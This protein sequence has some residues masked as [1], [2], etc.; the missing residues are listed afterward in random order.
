MSEMNPVYLLD[1]DTWTPPAPPDGDATL[2]GELEAGHVL[3]LPRLSFA[4]RPREEC[5]LDPRFNASGKN[6]SLEADGTSLK[7]ATG[8]AHELGALGTMIGRFRAQAAELITSLFPRY[9]PALRLARTSY[10]P[11]RLEGRASTWRTDDARLHVDAF[12]SQPVRGERILRV[13]ASVTP[14]AEPRVWRIGEPFEEL[15]LRFLPRIPRP[16]PGLAWT[17][18]L[19]GITKSRR[20]EYDHMMLRLHDAMKRDLDYQ[21]NSPQT[22]VAF[23]AGSV[24]ICFSDQ[25]PHAAMNG[26]F[27]IEQTLHLPVQAQHTPDRSP[28]RTL[29]RLAGRPLV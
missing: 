24:W 5:F 17:L 23:A 29:E 9:A 4:L 16:I 14:L 22:T 3:Y 27:V 25:I 1:T 12:P 15:I 10:R 26:Q 11:V 13:F 8:T 28:L 18:D 20:S 7:G 2:A 21:R 19:L 6:I